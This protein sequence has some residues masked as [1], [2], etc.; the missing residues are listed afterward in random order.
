MKLIGILLVLNSIALTAWWITTHN[1]N[2]AAAITVCLIAVFAGLGLILQDRITELTVKGVGTIRS[3]TEQVQID[4]KTVSDLKAR[5]ENQSATVDLVAKEASK[6]KELSAEVAEKNRRAEDKLNTLDEAITKA[7]TSLLSLDTAT[8]YAM[9]VLAAQNDDRSAF[10]TLRKWA[11]D[12]NNPFMAKAEQA[13]ST[14][15]E[16]HN[17]PISFSG[18]K[19]P[20]MEGFDPS[21]LSLPELSEQYRGAPTQLKPALLEYIWNRIDIP[22]MDRL[23]FMMG[24]MKTDPS[25]NAVEYAGRHFTSGTGQQIKP[26]AVEF[27][28]EWWQDHKLEYQGK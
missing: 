6:A 11:E 9:T 19:V 12:K 28:S 20:W 26:L 16:S 10:D 18:F 4:A 27:L 21:K 25:L 24:V 17:K 1:S 5:V 8:E 2:K 22:K 13:W 14:I 7:N 23:D 3:A 15:F